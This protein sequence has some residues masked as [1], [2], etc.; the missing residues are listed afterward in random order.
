MIGK[1]IPSFIA[2]CGLLVLQIKPSYMSLTPDRTRFVE[3]ITNIPDFQATIWPNEDEIN[4]HL[5]EPLSF[6]E[7]TPHLQA[8]EPIF[9]FQ[10]DQE[11]TDHWLFT[12]E[13]FQNEDDFRSHELLRPSYDHDLQ[14][15]PIASSNVFDEI[16]MPDGHGS[17][18]VTPKRKAN[19]LISQQT[20]IETSSSRKR[21][22]I[23]EISGQGEIEIREELMEHPKE[24]L[25]AHAE[26]DKVT[27]HSCP[28]TDSHNQNNGPSNIPTEQFIVNHLTSTR[29]LPATEITQGVGDDTES[30]FESLC[31]Y[32]IASG[33]PPNQCS[34]WIPQEKVNKFLRTYRFY[35]SRKQL[36]LQDC[37]RD[38]NQQLGRII[39]F[40]SEERLDIDQYVIFTDQIM[41][42]VQEKLKVW[43]NLQKS[44]AKR[45][46]I[47]YCESVN[48]K[49]KIKSILDYVRN[50]TKIS[51]FLI[52]T[53]MCLLKK[54]AT[55]IVSKNDVEEVLRF[56]KD[57]WEEDKA[58]KAFQS[59]EYLY[60]RR[61]QN[62]TCPDDNSNRKWYHGFTLWY[63]TSVSILKYW[64]ENKR[65]GVEHSSSDRVHH[66]TIAQMVQ[67]VID[68]S[69]YETS[70]IYLKEN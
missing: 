36:I 46:N 1:A 25:R 44:L 4:G 45:H 20:D 43:L 2:R 23:S 50:V 51:T 30:F 21:K 18:G 15:L 66:F 16:F 33:A 48:H 26:V 39:L 35:K 68:N 7:S 57:L 58:N 32:R 63:Y 70:G 55:E 65:G 29:P 40:L 59:R 69:D 61:M 64:R 41:N 31:T 60:I 54:N 6:S 10:V 53:D 62:L 13:L 19:A 28:D 37:S 67:L 8:S 49:R 52:I 27:G 11:E 3:T 56:M 17:P 22:V 24:S 47:A 34:F 42:P 5:A 9:D 38:I 12:H 14:D